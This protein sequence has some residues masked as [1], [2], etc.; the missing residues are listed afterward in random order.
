VPE[1]KIPRRNLRAI[2]RSMGV[3][4]AEELMGPWEDEDE[5]DRR[6]ALIQAG[7]THPP[8]ESRPGLGRWRIGA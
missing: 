4:A 6:W 7:R 5:F 3:P 8:R 1:E 2:Y